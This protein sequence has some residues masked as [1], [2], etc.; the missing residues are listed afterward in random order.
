MSTHYAKSLQEA[1]QNY[2][3]TEQAYEQSTF[4]IN[5]LNER[6]KEAG[7]EERQ[8]WFQQATLERCTEAR[9]SIASALK[10]NSPPVK[11]AN[12]GAKTKGD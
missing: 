8:T 9:E 11:T 2:H 10:N 4:K 6:E 1:L 5:Y 7:A 12:L 3:V